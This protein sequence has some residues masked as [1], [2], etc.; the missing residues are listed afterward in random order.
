MKIKKIA[1]IT[2]M[3]MAVSA[4]A[5]VMSFAATGAA[6]ATLTFSHGHDNHY[7]TAYAITQASSPANI[8]ARVN[9]YY[10]D[11]KSGDYYGPTVTANS[12]SVK[13]ESPRQHYRTGAS[14]CYYYQ[15]G[16][17]VHQSTAPMAFDW[18]W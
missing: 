16:S 4:S 17:Q 6:R 15:D 11:G 7:N 13:A 18:G 2:V 12:V 10:S 9:L 8:G 5:A 3:T 1:I 14:F